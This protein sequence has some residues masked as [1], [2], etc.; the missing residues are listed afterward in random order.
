MNKYECK[1]CGEIISDY[2]YYE[3][4]EF[5][6]IREKIKKIPGNVVQNCC[7]YLEKKEQFKFINSKMIDEWMSIK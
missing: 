7:D 6:G 2:E 1:T 5:E 3:C 4:F